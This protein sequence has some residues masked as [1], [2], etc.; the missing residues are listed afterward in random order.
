MQTFRAILVALI[1]FSVAMLPVAGVMAST[2]M[3]GMSASATPDCCPH[4]E[5]CDKKVSDN[6]ATA[7]GCALKCFNF[8][9]NVVSGVVAKLTAG[10][11]IKPALASLSLDSDP[12]APPLPPP[13]V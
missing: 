10:A 5:P 9:G 2:K 8:S 1:A 11:L 12:A 4:G 6:C 13:R 3:P 7:A